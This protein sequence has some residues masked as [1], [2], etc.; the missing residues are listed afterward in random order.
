M[1]GLTIAATV[2]AEGA[3]APSPAALAAIKPRLTDPTI[4][5]GRLF[6]WSAV[7]A[8]TALHRHCK[9]TQRSLT[10]IA[11]CGTRGVSFM[12][13]PSLRELPLG[14]SY[15]AQ[16]VGETVRADFFTVR[17]IKTGSVS[18]DSFIDGVR[19]GLIRRV[20]A[21]IGDAALACSVCGRD[22]FRLAASGDGCTHIPGMR[23]GPDGAVVKQGGT[24]CFISIDRA[25][26]T[27]VALAVEALDPST[28]ILGIRQEQGLLAGRELVLARM[29]VAG[30]WSAQRPA[31]E[32]SAGT[33]PA[34]RVE[35]AQHLDQSQYMVGV[36]SIGR[37]EFSMGGAR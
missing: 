18:S 1:D 17:G 14:Q 6:A 4:D 24:L 21:V 36:P 20:N 29:A 11:A 30:G 5:Q 2:R 37:A 27:A 13:G 9:F 12:A 8:T 3:G 34:R 32:H 22:P 10:T 33:E 23:Y 26:I 7:I 35:P 25:E 15:H 28:A 19:A 31:Q 16:V